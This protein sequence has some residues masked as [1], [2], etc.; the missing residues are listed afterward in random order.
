MNPIL[1]KPSS[2]TGSH[3]VVLG[4]E[5]GRTDAAGVG[6]PR[7]RP[8]TGGARRARV[9]A[10]ALRRGRG[11]GRRR[12]GGDQ[13]ARPRPRQPAPRPGCRDAGGAGGRHR[14]RRG[15][16]RRPRHA[17]TC[18]PTTSAATVGGIV[19]NRFRGDPALLGDGLARPRGPDR[20]PGARRAPAPR[21]CSA[22]R[23]RGLAR[24]RL[25]RRHRPA[26]VRRTPCGSPPCAS[27][28]SPTPPTS[29]RS[30]ASP[31][32]WCAGS[33]AR[34]SS[35]TPTS[36]WCR[37][38]GPRWPTSPGCGAPARRCAHL[39]GPG[40]AADVSASAPVSSCSVGAS[41]T[42]S[43]PA[44]DR[45]RARPARR[46]DGLRAGQGG[47]PPH[48]AARSTGEQDVSGYQIHL[49]RVH[50]APTPWLRAGRR[51]RSG[52]EAEGS[53]S[54]GRVRGTSLHGLFDADALRA[55][56][57]SDV[58][59]R[60]GRTFAP[61]PTAVRRPPRR[62]ARPAGRLAGRHLDMRTPCA[63]C[64]SAARPAPARSP[65]GEPGPRT[66]PAHPVRRT[67]TTTCPERPAPGR[68]AR[69][70]CSRRRAPRCRLRR[71]AEAPPPSTGC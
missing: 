47:A 6:R 28:T 40:G 49:G 27:P 26:G 36:S 59:D 57:L 1:L 37:A 16:R 50:G 8:A 67:S 3:V 39:A 18:C 52:A 35:P 19:I 48:R 69:A 14:A 55:A 53:A 10:P 13:P 51:R 38:A 30:S 23:H 62:A 2:A 45:R 7:S 34:A 41:S 46:R 24:R 22:A 15:V 63:T 17:S 71:S 32:W 65:A 25:R 61:H 4:R 29:T 12:C 11:R 64:A 42:T 5:V 44:P 9:P 60:A 68:S 66:P 56:I 21:S 20:R 58:A 43:S 31:T 54:Q 70:G 33:P